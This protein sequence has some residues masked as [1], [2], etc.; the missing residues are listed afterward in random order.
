MITLV[1]ISGNSAKSALICGATAST[2]DPAGSRTYFGG[3]WLANAFFTCSATSPAAGQSHGSPTPQPGA[4]AGSPPSP[5]LSAPLDG[6]GRVNIHPE[7]EDQSSGGTDTDSCPKVNPSVHLR[8]VT[9]RTLVM[10][11][12][13]PTSRGSPNSGYMR[14]NLAWRASAGRRG[15]R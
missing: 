5:P 15:R 7:P 2:T 3:S 6:Q 11:S 10:R 13:R 4:A 8:Y 12:S 1:G 9:G 14:D